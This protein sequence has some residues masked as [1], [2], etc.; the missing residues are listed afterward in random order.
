MIGILGFAPLS[1]SSIVEG[2][3]RIVWG[4]EWKSILQI[5]TLE[6]LKYLRV[7]VVLAYN[8]AAGSVSFKKKYTI[9]T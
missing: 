5:K 8:V 4:A 3:K 1:K 9:A 2:K 6:F 7:F